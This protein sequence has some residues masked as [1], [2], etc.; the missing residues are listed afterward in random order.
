[1]RHV[2][3]GLFG[4]AEQHFHVLLELIGEFLVFLI[5]PTRVERC[6]LVAKRRGAVAKLGIE[7]FQALGELPQ[8]FG[9][10]DGLGHGNAGVRDRRS[11]LV[12]VAVGEF[13][14]LHAGSDGR[15]TPQRFFPF[16]YLLAG[17]RLSGEAVLM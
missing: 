12:A 4:K 9:I 10:D 1:M 14:Q 11:G 15:G 8:C 17:G 7:F 2:L 3:V 6:K 13:F 16:F 5:A